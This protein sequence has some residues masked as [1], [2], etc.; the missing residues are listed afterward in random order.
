MSHA[1]KHFLRASAERLAEAQQGASA[2]HH[3]SLTAY[4]QMLAQLVDHRR[5]LK[6]IQSTE[7][8]IELK[9]KLLP[10][11]AAWIEGVL[12]ADTGVQDEVFVTCM[13][14]TMD[15]ADWAQ[16]LKM[17]AYAIKHDLILPDRFE[18]TL[19]TLIA[20]EIADA[21]LKP[22]SAVPL[23][24]LIEANTL[25]S[26]EDM[27]DQVRAKLFKAIG[28]GLRDTTDKLGAIDFLRTALGLFA[29]I[30]VKKDIEKLERELRNAQKAAGETNTAAGEQPAA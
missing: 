24:V 1:R 13:I 25:T 2:Q 17:A 23:D 4:E 16:A 12:K 10:D 20:E 14:W 30:G 18:R 29:N 15:V 5:Q 6:A 9:A 27:P 7:R 8:K 26:D 19:G 11:Y 3:A 22:D 28:Y 21:A